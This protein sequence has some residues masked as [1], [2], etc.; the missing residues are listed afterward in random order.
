LT[1][2]DV[3]LD[4]EPAVADAA[5]AV[6]PVAIPVPDMEATEVTVARPEPVPL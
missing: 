3:E 4:P 2:L 5:L 1:T 6:L